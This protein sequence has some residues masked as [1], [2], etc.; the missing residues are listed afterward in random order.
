VNASGSAYP[1]VPAGGFGSGTRSDDD[2]YHQA[3]IHLS[4]DEDLA[5]L[6]SRVIF[7]TRSLVKQGE[8]AN[9]F[10]DAAWLDDE[11]YTTRSTSTGAQ[12]Q[13]WTEDTYQLA[14]AAQLPGTAIALEEIAHGRLLAV[15]RE[16]SGAPLLQVLNGDLD[17]M[18]PNRAPVLDTSLNPALTPVREDAASPGSTLVSDLL[19]GAVSDPD[20]GALRGIAV[21]VASDF[22]GTWQYSLS[23][24]RSWEPMESPSE[25][26]ARLLPGWARVKFTPKPDFDGVV[27]MYYRAWD[28]TRGAAGDTFDLRGNT[29]GA[30]AFSIAQESATLTMIPVNDKPVLSFSETIGYVH[31]KPA[32]TLAAYARVTDIDSASFDGGLLRV[33]ITDG[34]AA[35]NRLSLGSGFTVDASNNVWQGTTL[36]GKRVSNGYATNELRIRLADGLAK[37]IA[38]DL[39][40]SVT[41]KTVGGAAGTRRVLFSLSD[42]DGGTSEEVAKVVNVT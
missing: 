35:S 28:Q 2:N 19:K 41:F 42:G 14:D 23:G 25:S 21:T 22:H 8:I 39:I 16:G 11:L 37:S 29:G 9:T 13:R 10:V 18:P 40:R 33:R 6:G 30:K 1:D 32:I 15:S 17:V 7:D 36:V 26:A 12:V 4:G 34:A 27:K 3:P 24:G 20:P 38:Q 5:L 31:D